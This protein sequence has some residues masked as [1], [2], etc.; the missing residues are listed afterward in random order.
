VTVV[1][2]LLLTAAC[3]GSDDD[4]HSGPSPAAPAPTAVTTTPSPV[5][6]PA[7]EPVA[8]FPGRS[9]ERSERGDW[10]ALDAELARD[11]STC[12]AVIQDGRLVHEAYWNGGTPT[13]PRRVYSIAKSLTSLLVGTFVDEGALA[14]DASAAG[15]IDE[16]RG[17][18][19]ESVTVGDLLSMTSGRRWSEA[20]DRQLIRASA[21]QTA[22]AT[23]LAQD[24]Q[25]GERWVYDNAAA[26]ALESV[27]DDAGRTDDVVDLAQDRLL[28]PLGMKDTTWGRDATGNALTYSGMES[29][30]LDLARVGHLMLNEGTWDDRQVLSPD[31][32]RRATTPSSPLNAAYGL[33][34]WTNAEGR[35]VEVLRQ[36]GFAA[37]KEPYEG[38]L[39]PGVPDDAYW[40]FGYGNQYVA[41]VPSRGVVAVRLGAR[42][43]TP[44]RVTF[45]GFTSDV[46]EVLDR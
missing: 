6:T 42:P 1:A 5:P 19:A 46:L 10:A 9:W 14:L 36:A 45:D 15:Q 8:V 25:P 40:A 31:F 37:D 41:V 27:L 29:T 3:S 2:A 30:C 17:S 21:D 11:G 18:A 4:E 34:W 24:R 22:Y 28:G 33:M 35:V 20:I 44:D 12:V 38:R 7:P 26:Q 43:A 23:D 16:W 39:A 32:V 13:G